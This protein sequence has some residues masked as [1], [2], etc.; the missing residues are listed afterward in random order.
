MKLIDQQFYLFKNR[1]T[2]GL[3]TSVEVTPLYPEAKTVYTLPFVMELA[4]LY[5]ASA[6]EVGDVPASLIAQASVPP[7]G[8]TTKLADVARYLILEATLTVP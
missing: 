1:D 4:L 8:L 3:L 7:S 2:N 6:V 5:V